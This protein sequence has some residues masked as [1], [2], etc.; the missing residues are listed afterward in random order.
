MRIWVLRMTKALLAYVLA[1]L[2]LA[3]QADAWDEFEARCLMPFEHFTPAVVD[4]L[5]PLPDQTSTGALS[6]YAIQFGLPDDAVLSVDSAPVRKLSELFY[7]SGRVE[8][9]CSVRGNDH[10]LSMRDAWV[11]Q[12]GLA[13]S[14][15]ITLAS[16]SASYNELDYFEMISTEW[17]EPRLIVSISRN[18]D[19]GQVGYNIL[20]TDLES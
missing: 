8:R 3:V 6:D 16:H 9:L 1:M 13:K 7:P 17:I 11:A 4:D 10:D 5:R 18:S 15:L 20:E 19:T 2:P 12:Q 14:Y